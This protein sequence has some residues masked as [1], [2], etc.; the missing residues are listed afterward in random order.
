[1]FTEAPLEEI[2]AASLAI[3]QQTGVRVQHPTAVELLAAAGCSVTD[4]D[5]VR[6]PAAVIEDVIE[7]AP[8]PA[9]S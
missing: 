9:P 8:A 2:H 4:R 3:L 6:I 1:M 5:L 7:A